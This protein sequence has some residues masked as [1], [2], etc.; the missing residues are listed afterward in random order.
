MPM[1]MPPTTQRQ[2]VKKNAKDEDY[3]PRQDNC[4]VSDLS[5]TGARLTY[6]MACTGANPMTGAGDFT[7]AAD[8]YSGQMRLKGKME[9]RDIEMTQVITARRVGACTAP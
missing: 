6:K 9:G 1:A 4:R 5:R 7:F 3:V 2:C 8:G